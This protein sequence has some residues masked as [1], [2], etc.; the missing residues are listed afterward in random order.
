MDARNPVLKRSIRGQVYVG[1]YRALRV[2]TPEN[3]PFSH[4]QDD[5]LVSVTDVEGKRSRF[6][7]ATAS[8]C[9]RGCP[10]LWRFW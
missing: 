9:L 4:Q 5:W 6:W 1:F 2:G 7:K 10:F 3:Q 8:G